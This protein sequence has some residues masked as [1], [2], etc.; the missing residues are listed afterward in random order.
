M[1]SVKV[2]PANDICGRASLCAAAVVAVIA[3]TN[4]F[5][6]RVAI[7][8]EADALMYEAL[9]LSDEKRYERAEQVAQKALALAMAERP[10]V[11]YKVAASY[12]LLYNVYT[13]TNRCMDA[14]QVAEDVVAF[15]KHAA[16]YDQSQE[17]VLR[18]GIHA[19]TEY[20]DSPRLENWG[21]LPGALRMLADA[22]VAVGRGQDAERVARESLELAR[23]LCGAISSDAAE[24]YVS[25]AD[26]YEAQEKPTIAIPALEQAASIYEDLGEYAEA[27]DV[28]QELAGLLKKCGE[29]ERAAK[30]E[31][32]ATWARRFW[33][34]KQW[35]NAFPFGFKGFLAAMLGTAVAAIW[36][37]RRLRPS[38]SRT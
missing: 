37:F 18:F 6:C 38:R 16:R 4:C 25:L 28:E 21:P 30:F 36:L 7:A 9:R 15:I 8:T 12:H 23:R 3:A 13:A 5:I 11:T 26:A 2:G 35:T 20:P 29:M 1:P 33:A 32:R 19:F 31:Y 10:N 22:Y 34:I 24:S 17:Q 14:L 27:A